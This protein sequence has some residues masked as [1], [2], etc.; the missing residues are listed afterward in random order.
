MKEN[1]DSSF[2]QLMGSEGGF[3]DNPSDPGG[4]TRYG[5][6]ERTARANGYTGDMRDFPIELAKTIA[7]KEYWDAVGCD[8]LPDKL[9]F[10]VFDCAYNSGP[11]RAAELLG[12]ALQP[13]TDDTEKVI[14]RFDSYRLLFLDS[15]HTW[16]T[17]GRGWCR[18]IAENL[19]RAAA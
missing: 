5:I 14:M 17:F 12:K 19:L 4:A 8:T 1:F 15:L 3:V 11:E 10:Q 6:T 16:P 18:R 7:K 13:A 2:D 9:D